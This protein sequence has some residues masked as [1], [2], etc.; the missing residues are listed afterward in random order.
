[1]GPN[2]LLKKETKGGRKNLGF[3]RM[4]DLYHHCAP[5]RKKRYSVP[6]LVHRLRLQGCMRIQGHL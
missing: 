4:K 2:L 3:S 6:I 5:L 1:M